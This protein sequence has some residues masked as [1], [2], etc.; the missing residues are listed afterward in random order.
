MV[1]AGDSPKGVPEM[2]GS[3]LNTTGRFDSDQ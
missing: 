3:S 1:L 2:G